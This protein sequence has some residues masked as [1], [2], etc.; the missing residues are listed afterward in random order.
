MKRRRATPRILPGPASK[1]SPAPTTASANS[2]GDSA[3]DRS[4]PMSG[5][6]PV[7]ISSPRFRDAEMSCTC[8]SEACRKAAEAAGGRGRCTRSS[9]PWPEVRPRPTAIQ[10]G[11]R[12]ESSTSST[13]LAHWPDTERQHTSQAHRSE[14]ANCVYSLIARGWSRTNGNDR[15]PINATTATWNR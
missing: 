10:L 2:G 14:E 8:L 6:P 15:G 13:K 5:P 9:M 7:G 1:A 11:I 12:R 4:M 3:P